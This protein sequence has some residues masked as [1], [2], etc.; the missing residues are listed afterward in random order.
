VLG[1][2]SLIRTLHERSLSDRDLKASNILVDLDR[3]EDEISLSLIDLVGVTLKFPL[4]ANRR[5]QNLA[6]LNLSLSGIT[7]RTRTDALRFLRAYLPG[8]LARRNEWKRLWKDVEQASH[9]KR[10]RNLRRGR[11]L[12]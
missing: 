9:T 6:R 8:G 12:S 3:L 2:A 1:L 7:G 10:E 5:I 4:P 11:P